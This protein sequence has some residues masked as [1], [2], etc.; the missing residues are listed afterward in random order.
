[1]VDLQLL[2]HGFAT[3]LSGYN[4]VALVLGSFFGIIIGSI[5]GLTA[6]WGLPSWSRSR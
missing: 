6:T 2:F 3:V 5:P 1:M 4:I